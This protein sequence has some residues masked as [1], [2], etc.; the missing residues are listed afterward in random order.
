MLRGEAHGIDAGNMN[1]KLDTVLATWNFPS[2]WGCDS[3]LMAM[4]AAR[5]GRT[6]AVIILMQNTV[7]N[8]Y[9]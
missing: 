2:A 1:R 9:L 3:G 5:L 4:T 8:R 7:K 6:D